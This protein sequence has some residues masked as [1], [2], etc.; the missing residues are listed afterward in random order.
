MVGF[1]AGGI[2]GLTAA[3]V[4]LK[5]FS[6][7]VLIDKDELLGVHSGNEDPRLVMK[8]HRIIAW[9]LSF[10]ELYIYIDDSQ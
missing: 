1:R 2:G 4:A 6:S 5:H 3:A 9:S 7:V 8:Y 10:G